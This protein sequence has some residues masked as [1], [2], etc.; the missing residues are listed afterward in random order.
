MHEQHDGSQQLRSV[1]QRLRIW[2]LRERRMLRKQLQRLGVRRL[3]QLR[4]RRGLRLLHLFGRERILRVWVNAVLLAA[5]LQHQRGL[6]RRIDL[7]GSKLL[8]IRRLHSCSLRK[9]DEKTFPQGEARC[10]G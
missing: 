1:R 6:R 9:S 7:C 4:R 5:N 3:S 2:R 10:V 8:R